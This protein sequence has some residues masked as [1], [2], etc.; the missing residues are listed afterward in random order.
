MSLSKKWIVERKKKREIKRM[1]KEIIKSVQKRVIDYPLENLPQL[2]EN[3]KTNGFSPKEIRRII[4]FLLSKRKDLNKDILDKIKEIGKENN[5]LDIEYLI[6]EYKYF[7]EQ[8][9]L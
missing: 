1:R 7:K 8:E 9:S 2:L 6:F 4:I 5:I 3:I